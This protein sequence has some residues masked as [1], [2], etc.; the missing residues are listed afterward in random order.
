MR[1]LITA[2]ALLAALYFAAG[3]FL[4]VG[5]THSLSDQCAWR[6][7]PWA[8]AL[9]LPRSPRL[10]MPENMRQASCWARRGL[11]SPSPLVKLVVRKFPTNEGSD[12]NA[13]E[14]PL[15]AGE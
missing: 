6:Q 10:G 9:R 7:R 12:D 5:W 11:A 2:T 8:A 4:P 14:D 1:P 13:H 3:W 15:P